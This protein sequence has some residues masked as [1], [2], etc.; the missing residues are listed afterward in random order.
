MKL[1]HLKSMKRMLLLFLT[2]LVL[3]FAGGLFFCIANVSA[4]S[5]NYYSIYPNDVTVSDV[6]QSTNDTYLRFE[7]DKGKGQ[8]PQNG[9]GYAEYILNEEIFVETD[10]GTLQ[11]SRIKANGNTYQFHV[12]FPRYTANGVNGFEDLAPTVLK[13]PRLKAELKEQYK[14]EYVGIEFAEEI[15]FYQTEDG[16]WSQVEYFEITQNVNAEKRV[17]RVSKLQETYVLPTPTLQEGKLFLGWE[18]NETIFQAG[19]SVALSAY[20]QS[21]LSM[22]AKVIDLTFMDGASIRFDTSGDSG[23]RFSVTLGNSGDIDLVEEIG[24][25]LI[26]KDLLNEKEFVWENYN[27]SGQAKKYSVSKEGF[28]FMETDTFTLYATLANVL[29]S[30][31]NRIFLARAYVLVN[32]GE[33]ESEYVWTD[34][35]AESSVYEVASTLLAQNSGFEPWQVQILENYVN[36]VANIRFDGETVSVVNVSKNPAITQATATESNGEVTVVLTTDEESFAAILYNGE[37]IKGAA[38]SYSDGKLT[39]TFTMQEE[40]A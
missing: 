27:S 21:G 23:I 8:L 19:E 40:V 17:E 4:T 36:K 22:T 9:V 24:I 26:P 11:V 16:G 13:F 5:E 32:Y 15:V 38:Q 10:K 39:I 30:N 33:N 31:F 28:S 14:G 7:Y 37:R 3:S 20:L 18:I 35:T 25:I 12:F 1:L 29:E 34:G 2:F 6:R